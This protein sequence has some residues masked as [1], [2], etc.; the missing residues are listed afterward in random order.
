MCSHRGSGETFTFTGGVVSP[1][2][3]HLMVPE[4]LTEASVTLVPKE[5]T[6]VLPGDKSLQSLPFSSEKK[7]LLSES[8][9][10]QV[11]CAPLTSHC[12]TAGDSSQL[13]SGSGCLLYFLLDQ[14]AELCSIP[15]E[16][17]QIKVTDPNCWILL[18]LNQPSPKR[19]WLYGKDGEPAVS[20]PLCQ[21]GCWVILIDRPISYRNRKVLSGF[22]HPFSTSKLEI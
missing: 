4:I 5:E 15:D 10:L 9:S 17:N 11:V 16:T 1:A 14:P 19:L 7:V 2:P 20:S 18:Q 21:G 3:S 13:S 6:V 8:P 22:P 12:V